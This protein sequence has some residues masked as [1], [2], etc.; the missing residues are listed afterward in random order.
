MKRSNMRRGMTL[1][2]LLISGLIMALIGTGIY[3]MIRAS[4]DS[5]NRI[6]NQNTSIARSRQA[7]DDWVDQLRGAANIT[8]ADNTSVTLVNNAAQTIKF[9]KSGTD[10]R[11]TINSL[12]T[13]GDIVVRNVSALDLTYWTWSGTA[14]T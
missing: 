1:M 4:Y 7:V 3:N 12:P 14:W 13:A 11:R 2:E 10:I 5:Q 6:I 9:W 8:Q